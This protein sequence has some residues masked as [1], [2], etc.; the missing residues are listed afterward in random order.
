MR[1]RVLAAGLMLFGTATSAQAAWD[2]FDP[3]LHTGPTLEFGYS[4]GGDDL[5]RP[6]L[7]AKHTNITGT[8]YAGE[9]LSADVGMIELLGDSGFGLKQELGAWLQIPFS[10]SSQDTQLSQS[11]D[12]L[13]FDHGIANALFFY[14]WDIYAIGGGITYQ[15]HVQMQGGKVG[16]GTLSDFENAHGWIAMFQYQA[17]SFRYTHVQYQVKH[18]PTVPPVSGDNFGIYFTYQF[19]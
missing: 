3:V 15:P 2:D 19:F 14:H 18:Q 16:D 5:N 17:I 12:T 6:D 9:G 7:T 8:Y 11:A 13:T 4:V 10:S 1:Y